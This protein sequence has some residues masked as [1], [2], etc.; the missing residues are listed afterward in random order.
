TLYHAVQ[1]TLTKDQHALVTT[2]GKEVLSLAQF[3]A[4]K[5]YLKAAGTKFARQGFKVKIAD[6]IQESNSSGRFYNAEDIVV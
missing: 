3:G 5:E 6:W 1:K 2:I 4:N